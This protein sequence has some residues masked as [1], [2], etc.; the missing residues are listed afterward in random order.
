M[1]VPI[2]GVN[3]NHQVRFDQDVDMAAPDGILLAVG[4]LRITKPPQDLLL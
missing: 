2:A 1:P 4:D 3:L